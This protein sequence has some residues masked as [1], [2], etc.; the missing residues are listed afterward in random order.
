[1]KAGPLKT[2]IPLLLA[3][4]ILAGCA[5]STEYRSQDGWINY[6]INCS[7]AA[8]NF[9]A[10]LDKAGDIC[11]GRGYRVL[12]YEGGQLPASVTAMPKDTLLDMLTRAE[13]LPPS[14]DGKIE[15][16]KLYIRCN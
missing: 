2:G 10:C 6:V 14:P 8:S 13:A 11:R 12:D 15:I 1:M 9:G 16:R 3:T 5:F 7:G 4:A